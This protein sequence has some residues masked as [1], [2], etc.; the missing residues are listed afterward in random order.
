MTQPVDDHGPT[1]GVRAF[2]A[3]LERAMAGDRYRYHLGELGS[4]KE[5]DP[6]VEA[7]ADRLLHAANGHFDV[8]SGCGHLRSEITGTGEVELLQRPDAG[9]RSYL[10][11]KRK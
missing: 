2:E 5:A 10:A 3:W 7:I 9:Q 1:T 11:Q 8:V 6:E 4:D